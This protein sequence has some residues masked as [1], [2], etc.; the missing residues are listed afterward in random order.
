VDGTDGAFLEKQGDPKND[1]RLW[2][3]NTYQ[4]S[5]YVG[6]GLI[7]FDLYCDQAEWK[8]EV[9]RKIRPDIE[10]L[11][12]SQNANGTWGVRR[13]AANSECLGIGDP[14]RSP[15]VVNLLIWYYSHVDKDP[16]IVNAVRKFDRFLLNPSRRRS[17]GC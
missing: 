10:F 17:L 3:E 13:P 7:A 2:D 11:L 8:P 15:G 16:R 1:F 12:R 6:E 9:E 4:A 14:A 5:T